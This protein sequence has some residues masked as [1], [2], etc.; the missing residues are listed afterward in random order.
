MVQKHKLKWACCCGC[1]CKQQLPMGVSDV[2]TGLCWRTRVTTPHLRAHCGVQSSCCQRLISWGRL[3]LFSPRGIFSLE[4]MFKPSS[5]KWH[6][7]LLLV[8]PQQSLHKYMSEV[9]VLHGLFWT[10]FDVHF[11]YAQESPHKSTYEK[12]QNI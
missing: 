1:I 9:E 4:H 12:H 7:H 3:S 8:Q 5:L 10:G 2:N 6:G 11:K